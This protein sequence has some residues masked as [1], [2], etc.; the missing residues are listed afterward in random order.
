M[1]FGALGFGF[2]VIVRNWSDYRQS[3]SSRPTSTG[4]AHEGASLRKN[5]PRH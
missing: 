3:L 5:T 1:A 2:Y 4:H